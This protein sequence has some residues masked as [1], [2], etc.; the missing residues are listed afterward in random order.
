MSIPI[1]V[2]FPAAQNIP[3]A[4]PAQLAEIIPITRVKRD[5][6]IRLEQSIRDAGIPHVVGPGLYSVR[7]WPWSNW[8]FFKTEREAITWVRAMA[9]GGRR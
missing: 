3:I 5:P 7:V 1:T 8:V 6:V 2:N 9:E 4:H